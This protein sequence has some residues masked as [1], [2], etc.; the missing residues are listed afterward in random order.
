MDSQDP[1]GST[2]PA[3]GRRPRKRDRPANT[4]DETIKV[5]VTMVI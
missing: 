2:K 3:R 5:W 4:Q 1:N